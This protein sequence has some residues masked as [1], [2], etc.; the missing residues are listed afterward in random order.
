LRHGLYSSARFAGC[1]LRPYT[2]GIGANF[3]WLA[4]ATLDQGF[5]AIKGVEVTVLQD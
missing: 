4:I 1:A 5:R 3:I 2:F